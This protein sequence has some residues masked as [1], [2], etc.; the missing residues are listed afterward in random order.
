MNIAIINM[1][2]ARLKIK[3]NKAQNKTGRIR[4]L[5]L[6]PQAKLCINNPKALKLKH[7]NDPQKP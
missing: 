1:A 7:T 5:V 3:H 4:S 2:G 6:M